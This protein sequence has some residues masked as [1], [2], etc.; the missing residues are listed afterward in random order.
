MDVSRLKLPLVVAGVGLLLG[1]FGDLL[2]YDQ[3]PGISVPILAAA[4][5]I[6][7]I[8]LAMTQDT[9]I[10]TANLW[11]I[12]PLLF[13]AI[14]TAVRAAPLLMF[15]NIAGMLGLLLLLANRLLDKPIIHL[16][17]AEFFVALI[18]TSVSTLILAFPLLA[19][20][21]RELRS[22]DS[23]GRQTARRVALG[24]VI[25]SPF[26]CIFT[27]LFA[28]ADQ[29]FN[30]ALENVFDALNVGNFFGQ[31]VFT[32]FLSVLFMGLLTYTLSR[33]IKEPTGEPTE[34]GL[35]E[36]TP[37]GVVPVDDLFGVRGKLGA[38]EGAVVLF[39]VNALFLV[40][41]AIQFAA[42]F[43]GEAFLRSQGL[44]YSEYA[45]KGFFEL[46]AVAVITL[47][48][49]LFLDYLT[50]RES[51]RQRMIFLIGSGLMTILT[52]IIL[53]SAFQRMSLYESAYGF[54]RL[55]V[56]S[57]VFMIWLAVLLI[58]F[59]G[60]L[61]VQRTRMFATTLL[62][63]AIGFTITLDVLN[64]DAFIA[65][66]NLARARAGKE[67]DTDYLGSLSYDAVPVIVSLMNQNRETKDA[68][69]PWLRVHLDNL[70]LRHAR[71][72]WPSLHLA[73]ER[74]YAV[75]FTYRA[76]IQLYEPAYRYSRFD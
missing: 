27:I 16:N 40:F 15:L 19:R 53:I 62:L 54:T 68:I 37:P 1:G 35:Q 74:A 64:P 13:L 18:E 48:L 47:S 20:A 12:A 61:L 5:L 51:P 39:S 67:L 8:A 70:T 34:E 49:I 30:N 52:V 33:R 75:M 42:M 73:A 69:G 43:G 60:L 32:T 24:L 55:R 44:T 72:G 63:F 25:A 58:G 6:G 11:L 28:S 23:V 71:G 21:V 9:A 57:H 29:I 7:M 17:L 50:G 26:L 46:L 10:T 22:G 3:P 31:L 38:L 56:H 14:M 59:Y 76:D 41:V 65:S 45:R 66:Q 36:T 2:L 4:L